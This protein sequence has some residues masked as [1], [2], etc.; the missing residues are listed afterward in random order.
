AGLE[1]ML[2]DTHRVSVWQDFAGP[3]VDDLAITL[4]SAFDVVL[5]VARQD[6]DRVRIRNRLFAPVDRSAIFNVQAL[7]I[8]VVAI[9]D[10]IQAFGGRLDAIDC[11]A[12]RTPVLI[13]ERG[14]IEFPSAEKRVAVRRHRLSLP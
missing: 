5:V 14:G 4:Q 6:Q 8:R 11:A 13:V 3:A 10:E 7:A 1:S 12:S 9:E 2:D